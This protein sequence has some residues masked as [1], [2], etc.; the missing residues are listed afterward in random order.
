MYQKDS[1]PG[2]YKMNKRNIINCSILGCILV[3]L[4][5]VLPN[6]TQNMLQI[7]FI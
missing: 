2:Y 7:A 5:T 1:N 6:L 3:Q 4:N